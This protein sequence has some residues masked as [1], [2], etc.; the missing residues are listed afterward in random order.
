MI[1]EQNTDLVVAEGISKH[2]TK[3]TA[4][5]NV[6][7]RIPKDRISGLLG[8]N[9]AGKTTFIRILTQITMADSGLIYFDGEPLQEKHIYQIGYLPEERGLYKKMQVGEQLLYLAQLKGLS[10][11]QAKEKLHYWLE[12]FEIGAWWKKNVEDLSKGMQQKVQFISTVLHQPKLIILDE[13][14]SGFDPI[15]ANLIKE[16]I[17]RLKNEGSTIVFSTHRME[18]VEELC[19]HIVMIHQSKKVLDGDK[20]SIKDQFSNQ[21]FE[22]KLDREM[23]AWPNGVELIHAEA[24]PKGFSYDIQ[25][26][27]IPSRELLSYVLNEGHTVHA[28]SKKIPSMQEIFIKVANS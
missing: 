28:F 11:K 5:D 9:G 23:T 18:S 26:V 15:N 12:R 7:L 10:K 25:A 13:P 22:L 1:E 21:L 4:L 6:S 16:E 17:L 14:F 2:Y 27:G 19:D 24:T 20:E 3:H 8:P